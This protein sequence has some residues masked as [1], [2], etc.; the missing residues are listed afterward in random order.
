MGSLLLITHSFFAAFS[1]TIAFSIPKRASVARVTAELDPVSPR[2]SRS[3][4]L[5]SV[6]WLGNG[7]AL[8]AGFSR[9][10]S[11]SQGVTPSP[12]IIPHYVVMR[13]MSRCPKVTDFYIGIKSQFP[14]R[15]FSTQLIP[16]R[17]TSTRK[18]ELTHSASK[19]GSDALHWTLSAWHLNDSKT[20][21]GSR[22]DRHDHI[23][24][25]KIGLAPPF[26]QKSVCMSITRKTVF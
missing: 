25:G 12:F 5:K 18:R 9:H 3:R 23:G 10:T 7:S 24:K 2:P 26:P 16:V 19:S 1:G 14:R 15:R 11:S 6:I 17:Y 20:A 4:Q 21:L 22:V 8:S 13:I